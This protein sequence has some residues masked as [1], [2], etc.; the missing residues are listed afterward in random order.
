MFK[1]FMMAVNDDQNNELPA[2]VFG[3]QGLTMVTVDNGG[4]DLSSTRKRR[5]SSRYVRG[6][7]KRRS[8]QICETWSAS[9]IQGGRE[10]EREDNLKQGRIKGWVKG[11]MDWRH[12]KSTSL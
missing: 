8:G 9:L 3:T 10:G 11:W 5:T 12:L 7:R 2:I 6:R 4:K 1:P